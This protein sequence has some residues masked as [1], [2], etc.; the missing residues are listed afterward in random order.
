MAAL[1]THTRTHRVII[2]KISNNIDFTHFQITKMLLNRKFAHFSNA[3][4]LITTMNATLHMSCFSLAPELQINKLLRGFCFLRSVKD[5]YI[6]FGG[7]PC[8]CG[9]V[10]LHFRN[11]IWIIND[12]SVTR[13]MKAKNN[14]NLCT[15][16]LEASISLHVSES[17]H[18]YD[19]QC[20]F[21]PSF[22]SLHEVLLD[23]QR[24]CQQ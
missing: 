7:K 15:R 11:T 6:G 16:R 22:F 8:L 18:T 19:G 3:S 14:L 21:I 23:I 9:K 2:S 5:V 4:A 17:M 10:C 24:N 1:C 13:R 20:H 12:Q